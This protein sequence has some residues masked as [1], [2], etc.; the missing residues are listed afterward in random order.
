MEFF[1]IPDT[2]T[3]LVTR[4][5]WQVLDPF[6]AKLFSHDQIKTLINEGAKYFIKYKNQAETNFGVGY[7]A[8]L[9]QY[10]GLNIFS[11]A[12][13]IATAKEF[14][15]ATVFVALQN[16]K[17]D[18][19]SCFVIGIIAGNIFFDDLVSVDQVDGL[20][21]EYKQLCERSRRSFMCWGDVVT[22]DFVPQHALTLDE[23]LNKKLGKTIELKELKNDPT[24][25]FVLMA[26]V[27]CVVF[28]L[29]YAAY[30]WY[31]TDQKTFADH[32]RALQNSPEHI[33]KESVDRFLAEPNLVIP[34]VWSEYTAQ[35]GAFPTAIGGW[36]LQS[37]SCEGTDC[38]ALWKSDGGTYDDF[39]VNAYPDWGPIALSK[40][41]KDVL[42]DLKTIQH[43]FKLRINKAKLPPPQFWPDASA[44]AQ[45]IGVQWQK[46]AQ[47]GWSALLNPLQQQGIPPQ[48][49]PVAVARHPSAIYAMRWQA[50]NQ[51]W[52]LAKAV[53]GTFGD[54]MTI[55][56]V[57]LQL[58]E[59]EMR[60]AFNGAGYAYTKK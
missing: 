11:L 48:V 1:V 22:N 10:A 13:K 44:F 16:D 55:T 4:L 36:K 17:T 43:S 29:G 3:C 53:V 21:Y 54:N 18:E 24:L 12:S 38:L 35:L 31:K 34:V 41:E 39:K 6:E 59:K 5:Q 8:D 51:D 47:S 33:Y 40:N 7:E 27:I 42:A 58:N 20:F 52:D 9:D 46:L 23:A 28:L 19:N 30:D 45:A 49:A 26:F 56:H 37:I 50:T 60:V 25:Y 15:T 14:K 2:K 32:L 57:D